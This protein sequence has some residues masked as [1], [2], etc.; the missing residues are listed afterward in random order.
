MFTSILMYLFFPGLLFLAMSGMAVSWIDRKMTARL[1]WRVGPPPLQPLYDIRK[2]FAKETILPAGGNIPVFIAAPF[3]ALAIIPVIAVM[4][5]KALALPYPASGFTGDLVLVMYLFTIPPLAS[6]L[7]G[8]SSRN[9]FASLGAAREMKALMGYELPFVLSILAAAVKAHGFSLSQ[10]TAAQ[11]TGSSFLFSPSGILAFI[12]AMICLQAKLGLVPFD[13]PEAETEIAAGTFIEYSGPLLAIW[14]LD[15][16]MLLV[17]GPLF[18]IAVFWAGG[19]LWSLPFKYLL[20]MAALIVARN[21][22]PRIRIDQSLKFFWV[23]VTSLASA[24]LL[25]AA[26]GK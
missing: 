26:L 24:A 10:I 23:V 1:Q 16:M 17:T 20:I 9:P 8:S 3:I 2:L 19:P 12:T 6:I 18:I 5:G 25:M 13:M 11:Q 15:R 7:G 22:N 14:R 21:T 4:T